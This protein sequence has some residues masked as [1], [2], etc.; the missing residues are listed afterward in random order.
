[1]A[2]EGGEEEGELGGRWFYDCYGLRDY[3]FFFFPLP[4]L[5]VSLL[6]MNLNSLIELRFPK[7]GSR[8]NVMV[9]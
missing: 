5:V 7:N 2:L 6:A 9:S 1:M 8:M 4:D 3:G